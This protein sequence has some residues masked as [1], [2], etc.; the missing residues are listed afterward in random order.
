MF[1]RRLSERP[2]VTSNP[3]A[4]STP[5]IVSAEWLNDHLASDEA[6]V[7]CDIR[8]YLDGRDGRTAYLD[9]HLPGAH[10]VDMG[11]VLAGPAAPVAGRHPMPTSEAFARG[12]GA[13]GIADDATV[14]A[15]D[16]LG[17]MVAGRLVWMLRI[18]GL[19]AGLLDGGFTAW[20][21]PTET[22][23]VS[24]TPVRRTARPWPTE[25]MADADQV[26]AHANGGG[27]VIDSRAAPRFRG[28]TEPVDARA[29]HV[30]NAVNLPFTE[31]LGSDDRFLTVSEL[32][33]RF[34]EAGLDEKAIVYC[35]SGVSACNNLL[36][37]EAA[38]LGRPRLY[39]GSWSG[40]SSDPD[41]PV[42]TG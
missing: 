30:P 4:P 13:L 17:G 33:A 10:F 3:A 38:G 29:G 9:G 2:N 23:P 34:G 25:A 12:L 39:V 8:S 27:L 7:L 15:Y 11:T 16:D 40:W 32:A 24:A 35:G 31:N 19:E 5:P 42:A 18:L 1:G 26:A 36:A 41:R 37:I 22:G 14:I 21:G 6:V 20:T 28:E